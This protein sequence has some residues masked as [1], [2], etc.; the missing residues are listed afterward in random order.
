V[1]VLLSRLTRRITLEHVRHVAVVPP[2]AA[3]A[4]AA[5]VYRQMARD[6]GI[7]APPV[8]LHAPAPVAMAA[9]WVLLRE[10]LLAGP[11]EDRA[12]REAVAAGISVANS[13]PYCAEVH[14]AAMVGL[15]GDADARRVAAGRLDGV[16]DIRLAAAAAWARDG[17][18]MPSAPG[19][20]LVAVALAFH[21]FN[22]MVNV[23]LRDSPLPDAPAPALGGLRRAA[24][25]LFG[26]LA[27]RRC[28]PGASL[29]LL[30]A[31]PLP[32]DLAWSARAPVVADALGRVVAAVDAGAARSVPP[33]VRALLPRLL[34]DGWTPPAGAWAPGLAE[35]LP[36]AERGPGRLALLTA[37]QSWRVTAGD[38]AAA[39]AGRPPAESDATLVELTAWAALT[40]SRHLSARLATAG[41]GADPVSPARPT[42]RNHRDRTRPDRRPDPRR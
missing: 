16:T 41:G 26:R 12:V 36:A 9:S 33:G 21:Y 8:A 30:P 42:E 29:A 2:P 3:G 35:T 37:Y 4:A 40:T 13:C 38:V 28:A 18:P 7:L 34:A 20:E 1:G 17:R 15:R 11:P 24:A 6:F 25:G 39:R 14:H 31:A 22:R 10:C 27:A 23:F 19:P 5:A 32:A